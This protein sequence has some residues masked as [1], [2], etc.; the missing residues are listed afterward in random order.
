MTNKLGNKS[1]TRIYRDWIVNINGRS[2]LEADIDGTTYRRNINEDITSISMNYNIDAPPATC[3]IEVQSPRHK[4]QGQEVSYVTPR[5][6]L[7]K[8]FDE[9]I[10]YVKGR[11]RNEEGQFEYIETFRGVVTR[12][13]DTA[14]GN[15]HRITLN[16]SDMLYFWKIMRMN[17]SPSLLNRSSYSV[18]TTNA[19]KKA[20]YGDRNPFEIIAY[21]SGVFSVDL[22]LE[23]TM[24]VSKKLEKAFRN[25][26]SN[27]S[28]MDYWK[29]RLKQ[30]KDRT[31]LFGLSSI[32]VSSSTKNDDK[33]RRTSGLIKKLGQEGNATGSHSTRVGNGREFKS[34]EV[35]IDKNSIN[36]FKPY[37]LV[38]IPGLYEDEFKNRLEIAQEVARI[39]GFEFYQDTSGYIMFKPPFYNIKVSETDN[40]I[41]VL[42]DKD[43]ISADY[44]SNAEEVVTEM[45][46]KGVFSTRYEF[47]VNEGIKAFYR[48]GKLVR[49]YGVQTQ[50]VEVSW[51]RTGLQAL[52]FAISEMDRINSYRYQANFTIPGR[53]ELH[54]GMPLYIKSYDQYWYITGISHS[55]SGDSFTTTIATTAKRSKFYHEGNVL[56]KAELVMNLINE[57][58]ESNPDRQIKTYILQGDANKIVVRPGSTTSVRLDGDTIVQPLSDGDGY[59][60]IGG[61]EY[62]RGLFVDSSGDPLTSSGEKLSF[63]TISDII[64]NY[65]VKK[66]EEPE[67]VSDNKNVIIASKSVVEEATT[68][69][70]KGSIPVSP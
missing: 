67:T 22:A 30:T 13:V 26:P 70:T 8:D 9:V 57:D 59:E 25:D 45:I 33:S 5:G 37:E 46:V 3:D 12:I 10:V 4:V 58:E 65:E 34:L 68:P 7:V 32:S 15:N 39:C 49:D 50:N 35:S 24:Y 6:P 63:P 43:I 66:K 42:D 31:K 53:P 23:R 18:E 1:Y 17:I 28:I 27:S 61:F 20:I 55:I 69:L 11:F 48:D 16:C 60:V 62:G 38:F 2:V 64:T 47:N 36:S 56:K 29:K 52:Q 51:I 54:L 21:I 40:P 19:N 44:S 14:E 41:Y